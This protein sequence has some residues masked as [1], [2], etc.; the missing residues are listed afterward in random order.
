MFAFLKGEYRERAVGEYRGRLIVLR[1]WLAML[2]LLIAIAFAL[3]SFVTLR[4]KKS[5]ALAERENIAKQ[6]A[7]N[8]GLD[9][10]AEIK[11]INEMLSIARKNAGETPVLE[12]LDRVLGEREAGR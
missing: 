1:L 4:A 10:E 8:S 5:I 7:E 9:T 3:P 6:A 12:F 2:L 11:K